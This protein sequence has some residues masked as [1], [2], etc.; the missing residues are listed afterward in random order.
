MRL[1]A[2][3]VNAWEGLGTSERVN[4]NVGQKKRKS[5]IGAGSLPNVTIGRKVMLVRKV[6]LASVVTLFAL[7]YS[8]DSSRCPRLINI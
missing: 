6:L 7:A 5:A 4:N 1:I 2:A 8:L 3:A